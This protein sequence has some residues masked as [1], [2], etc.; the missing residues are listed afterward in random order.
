M[1][2]RLHHHHRLHQM[3][4]P[5]VIDVP[6]LRRREGLV[7]VRHRL[8][9]DV[10]NSARV[11]LRVGRTARARS[12]TKIQRRQSAPKKAAKG[13]KVAAQGQQGAGVEQPGRGGVAKGHAMRHQETSAQ[14]PGHPYLQGWATPGQSASTSGGRGGC[15]RS[16]PMATSGPKGVNGRSPRV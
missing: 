15:Q 11:G 7:A 8:A 3:G 6:A 16:M 13:G 2:A 10:P 9:K 4:Q 5:C 1:T 14:D 12:L